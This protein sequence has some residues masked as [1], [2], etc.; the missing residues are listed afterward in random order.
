MPTSRIKTGLAT[1]HQIIVVVMVVDDDC[2]V[3]NR[4]S[5]SVSTALIA[6]GGVNKGRESSKEGAV[7]PV[8]M[9][10]HIAWGALLEEMEGAV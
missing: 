9:T 3:P 10:A 5:Y 2:K 1:T 6:L 7:E 4:P 8:S